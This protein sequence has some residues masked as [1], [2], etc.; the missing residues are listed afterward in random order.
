[1]VRGRMDCPYN[2]VIA[3]SAVCSASTTWLCCTAI[4][5]VLECDCN[6]FYCMFR[7]TMLLLWFLFLF[8]FLL[9]LLF[10]LLVLLESLLLFLFMVTA[11]WNTADEY[12]KNNETEHAPDPM[13]TYMM[14][15]L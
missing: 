11:I 10:W 6:T 4:G 5:Y 1:M 14:L 8:L 3:A 9:L 2:Y 13:I 7:G 12:E 15:D